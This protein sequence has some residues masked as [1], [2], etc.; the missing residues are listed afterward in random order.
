ML[1]G[2]TFRFRHR[3]EP[4]DDELPP[5]GAPGAVGLA[6]FGFELPDRLEP[7]LPE[8]PDF[9]S[10]RLLPRLVLPVDELASG[11]PLCEFGE[12]GEFGELG[13]DEPLCA[14]ATGSAKRVP[15]T[16]VAKTSVFFIDIPFGK[17][18]CR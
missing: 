8:L 10:L 12:F 5:L 1:S 11:L 17:Y 3:V 13:I 4:G 14:N 7:E 16:I 18:G 15:R 6:P 9:V 2:I